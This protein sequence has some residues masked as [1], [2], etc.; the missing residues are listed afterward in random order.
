MKLARL[1]VTMS[2]SDVENLDDEGQTAVELVRIV[3]EK[4]KS[5]A[6]FKSALHIKPLAQ[7]CSGKVL[8][9]TI[10]KIANK[11]TW[12][13]LTAINAPEILCDI[14]KSIVRL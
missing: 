11:T 13:I 12:K 14:K 5:L 6:P 3:R 10:Q 2:C 8:R 1:G 9:D 7:T 4:T